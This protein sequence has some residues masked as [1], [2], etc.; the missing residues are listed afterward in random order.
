[1]FLKIITSVSQNEKL[2]VFMLR[3]SK[4]FCR[5]YNRTEEIKSTPLSTRYKPATA[6]R[7]AKESRRSNPEVCV[8]CIFG[9]SIKHD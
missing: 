7:H 4:I 6:K 8:W 1:M 3:Q 9:S 5:L 2:Q